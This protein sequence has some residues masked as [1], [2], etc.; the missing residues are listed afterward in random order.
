MPIDDAWL[1]RVRELCDDESARIFEE[2]IRGILD[3]PDARARQKAIYK[4]LLEHLKEALAEIEKIWVEIDEHTLKR[5]E[6]E[7]RLGASIQDFEEKIEE[8]D[9]KLSQ[10]REALV[11]ERA[12]PIWGDKDEARHLLAEEYP[13]LAPWREEDAK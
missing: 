2:E 1:Q 5:I 7:A 13:D 12:K 4:Y 8:S 11:C 10:L 6:A 9:T 3:T